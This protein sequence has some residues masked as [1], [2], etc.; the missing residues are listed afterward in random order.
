MAASE[1]GRT[2]SYLHDCEITPEQV[3]QIAEFIHAERFVTHQERIHFGSWEK[4]L[5]SW[6]TH[7]KSSEAEQRIG[8]PRR[9]Y[10]ED[11]SAPAF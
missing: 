10:A 5:G 11:D 7:I 1:I 2:A 9:A 3:P 8:Q 6:I 4:F